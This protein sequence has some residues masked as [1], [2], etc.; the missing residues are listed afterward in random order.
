MQK[1]VKVKYGFMNGCIFIH[2]E[3]GTSTA[4]AF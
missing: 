1:E 4:I 3:R 2:L